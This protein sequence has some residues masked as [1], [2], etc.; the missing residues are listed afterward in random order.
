MTEEMTEYG[1]DPACVPCRKARQCARVSSIQAGQVQSRRY[2]WAPNRLATIRLPCG[3]AGIPWPLVHYF[4]TSI[5]EV[6]CSKHGPQ[7]FNTKEIAKAREKAQ[8]EAA[9]AAK[10][11]SSGQLTLDDIPPF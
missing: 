5:Y 10:K 11:R 2:E 9:K 8:K 4:G 3:C 6:D 7:K 1:C